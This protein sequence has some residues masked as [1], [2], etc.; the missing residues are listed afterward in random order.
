M[1][2]RTASRIPSAAEVVR[3][4]FNRNRNLSRKQLKFLK[5]QWSKPNLKLSKS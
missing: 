1:L 5:L 4:L 2:M 3:P